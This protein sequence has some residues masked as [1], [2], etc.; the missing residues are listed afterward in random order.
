VRRELGGTG[1]DAIRGDLFA[2]GISEL[3]VFVRGI[4]LSHLTLHHRLSLLP[5]SLSLV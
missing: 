3:L 5:F 1:G 4:S 2:T